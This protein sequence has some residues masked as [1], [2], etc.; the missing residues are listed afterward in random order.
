[1]NKRFCDRC[2]AEIVE[3]KRTLFDA[4]TDAMETLKANF[5]GKH[6]IKYNVQVI[7]LD[8]EPKIP[9]PIADLCEQCDQELNAFMNKFKDKPKT[10]DIIVKD[11]E[12]KQTTPGGQ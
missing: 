10:N 5:G 11:Q 1:M 4:V 12:E 9:R 8:D 2:G 7:D 3:T 6:R